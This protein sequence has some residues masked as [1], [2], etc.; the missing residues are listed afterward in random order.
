MLF[1]CYDSEREE[2]R[3]C[4]SKAAA[5][6][7]WS[8]S[9]KLWELYSR[10]NSKVDFWCTFCKGNHKS[11]SSGLVAEPEARRSILRRKGKCFNCLQ[12]GH[13]SPN[14]QSERKCYRCGSK[15]HISIC[16]AQIQKQRP[17]AFPKQEE[18]PK[19]NRTVST[20]LYFTRNMSNE[21]IL[22]QTARAKVHSPRSDSS[23]QQ[24][25]ILFDSCSQKSYITT[26]LRK[27]LNLQAV[28][29]ETVMIKT[30]GNEQPSV[31]KCDVLQLAVECADNLKVYINA[32][33]ID[34]ICSPLS[35]QSIDVALH[36]YPH[37]QGL[38]LADANLTPERDGENLEVDLM[39]GHL[40]KTM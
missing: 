19:G 25:R 11:V 10:E 5:T 28:G 32:Y 38:V 21:H 31:K 16:T 39:I 9:Y 34:F 15:H 3:T 27:K 13:I 40:S 24:V 17:P 29:S 33:E 2:T 22:L 36:D 30:F 8:V 4:Q 37:L 26:R 20:N 14:C 1:E 7:H 18:T 23:S 6:D 12:S 35:N